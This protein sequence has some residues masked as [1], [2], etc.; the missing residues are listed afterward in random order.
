MKDYYVYAL[1]D[2]RKPGN[3]EYR[4]SN[5]KLAR[6]DYEPFYIGK[7]KGKRSGSHVTKALHTSVNIPRF[8]KIRKIIREGYQ[9][10]VRRSKQRYSE[11]LAFDLEMELITVIGRADLGRGPLV[12]LSNG[13]EGNSGKIVSRSQRK[14]LSKITKA[15]FESKAERLRLSK[16]TAIRL[17]SM[18][19]EEK[20]HLV[21]SQQEGRQR[22]YDSLGYQ[23]YRKYQ[24]NR[25]NSISNGL[26]RRS[27]SRKRKHY[28]N[29]SSGVRAAP[30]MKCPYCDKVGRPNNM[31]RY[32]FDNCKLKD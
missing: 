3:Y 22:F 16:Q 13:G 24:I 20:N 15:R 28:S 32:H 14:K 18:S 25:G 19:P 26:L 6:Y 23:G 1:L 5:G 30:D 17:A 7:G 2:T 27:E 29:L 31:K 21:F 4:L 12:N 11:P 9:V 8:N 10:V